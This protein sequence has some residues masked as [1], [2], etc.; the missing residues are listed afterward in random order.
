[1][2]P[3]KRQLALYRFEDGV[4]ALVAPVYPLA[5]VLLRGLSALRR[6]FTKRAETH[7]RERAITVTM[8]ELSNLD[9]RVLHDIGVTRGNIYAFSVVVVDNPGA[10][11]RKLVCD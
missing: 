10:D 11:P 3:D 7:R 8:R 9:D 5:D 4:E 2:K 1:M 6:Y